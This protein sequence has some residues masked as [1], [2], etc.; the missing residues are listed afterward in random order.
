MKLVRKS[1]STQIYEVLKEDILAH[2]IGFGE[3][4][5]N[6]E[7]QKRFAV[8]STPVRDAINHLNLDG[9]IDH[10]TNVGARV[11]S[12]DLQYAL[13]I[14]EIMEM[15]GA[16]ALRLSAARAPAAQVAAALERNLKKQ[17]AAKTDDEYLELDS[18]FHRIFFL[19]CGN[20]RLLEEY[21]RFGVLQEMLVRYFYAFKAARQD[22][23]LQHRRIFE[24]YQAGD[25]LLALTCLGEHYQ[26][27]ET[28][29]REFFPAEGAEG[30][31]SPH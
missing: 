2:R 18:D 25:T 17:Q 23:V 6:R 4:L 21:T 24:A 10:I 9:L 27:A 22:S 5:S 13:D 8:S 12:F 31:P 14:N 28:L 7:L 11:I 3:K 20:A 16:T 19:H 29:F 30:K 26:S 15:L 1:L